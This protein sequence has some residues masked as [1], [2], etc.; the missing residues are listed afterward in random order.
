MGS[1][2]VVPVVAWIAS[3]TT[4]NIIVKRLSGSLGHL[5]TIGQLQIM[6]RSPWLYIACV[7]YAFCALLYFF[8]LSRLPLS[9]AGP[10]FMV[11]GVV[12][13][14]AIGA[15]GFGE[16]MGSEKLIGMT[17]CMIGLGLIYG[18]ARG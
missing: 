18:G 14:A 10:M 13:T 6:L 3:F 9:V 5:S 12:I 4:L 16:P 11:L 8:L 15:F 1:S 7:L 17:V 2:I